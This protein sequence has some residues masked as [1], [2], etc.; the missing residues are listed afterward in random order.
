MTFFEWF[1]QEYSTLEGLDIYE[2]LK[3]AW[4]SGKSQGFR[5]G[6]YF[7]GTGGKVWHPGCEEEDE[8]RAMRGD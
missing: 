5:E 2:Q 7:A 8:K 1:E 3:H 4:R 6:V